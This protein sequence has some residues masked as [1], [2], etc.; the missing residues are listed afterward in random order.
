M[1]EYTF[2]RN[3]LYWAGEVVYRFL[4]Y[5]PFAR[6]ES[7]RGALCRLPCGN[8]VLS[9]SA[10]RGPR[11]SAGK[12]QFWRRIV[13]GHSKSGESVRDWCDRHRVSEPSFYAWRRELAK[14][15]ATHDKGSLLP[16]TITPSLAAFRWRF[17]GPM[18]WWCECRAAVICNCS[19]KHCAC[20]GRSTRRLMRA[21]SAAARED[22]LAGRSDRHAQELRFAVDDRC[23]AAQT[24]SAVG[25]SVHLHQQ[26]SRPREAAVL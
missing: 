23:R 5:F 26:A 4:W 9:C 10:Q 17:A 8:W 2:A 14:R 24:G 7:L 20:C 13:E 16:V 18:V 22:L 6:N 19:A 25:P 12:E 11:R 15:D 3:L 1:M 21:E